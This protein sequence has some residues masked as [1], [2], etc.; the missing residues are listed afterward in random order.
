MTENERRPWEEPLDRREL[1]WVELGVSTELCPAVS[2]EASG[3]KKP[4]CYRAREAGLVFLFTVFQVQANARLAADLKRFPLGIAPSLTELKES[5]AYSAS[6]D[7]SVTRCCF[8]GNTFSIDPVRIP[9]R[10]RFV[11]PT[12]RHRPFPSCPAKNLRR[13]PSSSHCATPD[14]H[15]ATASNKRRGHVALVRC[16]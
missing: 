9:L 6:L 15:L 16:Y 1:W 2:L 8:S 14:I 10:N 4:V 12:T 5:F 3:C 11:P 7:Q 13:R